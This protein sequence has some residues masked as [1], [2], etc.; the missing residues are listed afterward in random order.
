[1]ERQ[2]QKLRAARFEE[3]TDVWPPGELGRKH[4]R[5]WEANQKGF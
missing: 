2:G 1:M 4:W 5:R 3:R